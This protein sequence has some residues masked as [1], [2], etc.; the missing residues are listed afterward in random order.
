MC[1]DIKVLFSKA[2]HTLVESIISA[3][4]T[5]APQTKRMWTK[6]LPDVVS[7]YI[8][9]TRD[10]LY[11][12]LHVLPKLVCSNLDKNSHLLFRSVCGY[13]D[14]MILFFIFPQL[15]PYCDKVR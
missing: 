13:M 12:R 3:K 15:E 6:M 8:L 10:A 7:L 9:R 1:F 2:D 5:T 11:N 4:C 14:Y